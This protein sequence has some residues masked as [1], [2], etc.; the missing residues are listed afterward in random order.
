[1]RCADEVNLAIGARI[2]QVRER[3][4]LWDPAQAP[5][6]GGSR[7][8]QAANRP[9]AKAPGDGDCHRSSPQRRV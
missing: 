3:I 7:C 8:E 6:L 1:V 2:A 5:A 9:T 4:T